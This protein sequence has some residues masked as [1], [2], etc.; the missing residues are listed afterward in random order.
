[1]LPAPPVGSKRRR[2]GE[3]GSHAAADGPVA[4]RA[5]PVA[6][7]VPNTNWTA[8]KAKLDAAAA[9]GHG[10][11]GRR[12]PTGSAVSRGSHSRP[13]PA[14]PA[15][16]ATAAD[17]MYA[18]AVLGAV[19]TE[20]PTPAP[21]ATAAAAVA[22]PLTT[23]GGGGGGG[24]GMG[25]DSKPPIGRTPV[26]KR[27]VLGPFDGWEL[28]TE[29]KRFVGLD[30]EMVGVGA[31]AYRSQ[32]AQVVLVDFAGRVIYESYVQ[33]VEAVVDYRTAVSGIRPEHLTPARAKTFHVVQAEVAALTKG[34]ILV[35]HALQNDLRALILPHA[36]KDIRDTARVRMYCNRYSGKWRPQKLRVLAATHLRIA[37]QEGEH[38]PAE[39]AQAAMALYR[40]RRREWELGLM[41]YG[42]DGKPLR[43]RRGSGAPAAA[44]AAPDAPAVAVDGA[45]GDVD[46]AA[47]VEAVAEVTNGEDDGEEADA[48]GPVAVPAPPPPSHGHPRAHSRSHPRAH[49]TPHTHAHGVPPHARSHTH[50][51]GGGESAAHRVGSAL[52]WSRDASDAARLAKAAARGVAVPSAARSGHGHGKGHHGH[53][54]AVSALVTPAPAAAAAHGHARSKHHAGAGR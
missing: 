33:P 38:A 31:D 21:A 1:M 50:H 29:Q 52:R 36:H 34:K 32:L 43:A 30:C 27:R 7:T 45:G 51:A 11:T 49:A 41:G 10:P 40:L 19:H 48:A 37:I 35:G 12:S 25:A 5:P 8:L 23:T 39:D 46:M 17:A 14:V 42:L 13:T 44:T 4:K 20:T 16:L 47:A 3:D 2:P 6:V 22:G 9:A 18:A 24:K 28:S 53:S 15:P 54:A 26:E